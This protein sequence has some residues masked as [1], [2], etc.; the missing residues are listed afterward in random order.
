VLWDAGR[1]V[2]TV[3]TRTWIVCKIANGT[4]IAPTATTA[5]GQAKTRGIYGRWRYVPRLDLFIG[6]NDSNDNVWLYRLFLRSDGNRSKP[7]LPS[8]E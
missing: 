6:Y 7:G 4:G 1:E 2:W 3:D 8:C 5:N